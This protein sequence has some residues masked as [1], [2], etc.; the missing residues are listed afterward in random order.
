MQ[1]KAEYVFEKI[2][3][4]YKVKKDKTALNM[5]LGQHKMTAKT[6]DELQKKNVKRSGKRVVSGAVLGSLLSFPTRPMPT[7]TSLISM[8]ITG[9]IGAAIGGIGHRKRAR[10]IGQAKTYTTSEKNKRKRNIS[11]LRGV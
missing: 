7:K 2:A 8:G 4:T 6:K 3:K 10:T 11:V 1:N 5:D 9:A